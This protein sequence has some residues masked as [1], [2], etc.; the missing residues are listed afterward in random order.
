V[1]MGKISEANH[2]IRECMTNPE[3]NGEKN[4]YCVGIWA[5]M[6]AND[7]Q[8]KAALKLLKYSIKNYIGFSP[9]TQLVKSL[10]EYKIHV[11]T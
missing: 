7:G 4:E 10:I 9:F 2:T 6:M 1:E 3:L 5:I 8:L 11:Q